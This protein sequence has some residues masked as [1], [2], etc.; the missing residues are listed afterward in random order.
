MQDRFIATNVIDVWKELLESRPEKIKFEIELWFRPTPQKRAEAEKIVRNIIAEYGGEIIKSSVHEEIAYHG[1]IAV[2][3]AV[4]IQQMI[5][6][7]D[8]TLI[9]AEQIM[10]IRASGQVCTKSNIEETSEFE[11]ELPEEPLA[12]LSIA[13]L[14]GLPL[15]NH[16]L[17]HNRLIIND[18]D[19]YEDLYPADR[20]FHGTTMASL[21]I[22]GDLTNP[23]DPIREKVYVRPIMK[24][25]NSDTEGIPDDELFVDVLHQSIK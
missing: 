22:C 23:I 20:R 21:I 14:D 10:W 12:P 13:L 6:N 8:N 16:S 11:I 4:E 25:I 18:V 3:P 2:C 7:L 9:N 17:L 15:A 5:D 19:E 24:P 1:L